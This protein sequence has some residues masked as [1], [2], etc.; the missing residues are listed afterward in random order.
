MLWCT[1]QDQRSYMCVSN[2]FFSFRHF[3][4][5]CY[6]NG[7]G[8]TS[9][10]RASFP[11]ENAEQG[12]GVLAQGA[13]LQHVGAPGPPAAAGGCACVRRSGLSCRRGTYIP[14]GPTG[15]KGR[16]VVGLP[17]APCSGASPCLFT[18]LLRFCCTPGLFLELLF[19]RSEYEFVTC[20]VS[21]PTSF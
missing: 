6:T 20:I 4:I 11:G 21:S 5:V 2:N 19:A 12:Q 17:R 14:A 10:P 18:S 8:S 9:L 13:A 1:D 7:A 15:V 16:L 3:P